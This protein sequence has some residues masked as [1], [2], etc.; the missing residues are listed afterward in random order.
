MIGGIVTTTKVGPTS[1]ILEVVEDRGAGHHEVST[2]ITP[3]ARCI[4]EG[5]SVFWNQS[6]I[7]WSPRIRC[8]RDLKLD[9]LSEKVLTKEVKG[10][11]MAG[12]G[13]DED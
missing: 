6:C 7:F 5:D 3:A 1:I 13:K 11:K 9:K 12:V 4:E 8:W 2:S 10:E